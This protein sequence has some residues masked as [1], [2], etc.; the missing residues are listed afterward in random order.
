MVD[1]LARLLCMRSEVVD[2]K[3][4]EEAKTAR[5]RAKYFFATNFL[6]HPFLKSTKHSLTTVCFR[7]RMTNADGS[8][9]N[10]HSSSKER[11]RLKSQS[12]DH[13]Y[14]KF[15]PP[16]EYLD[17]IQQ[18]GMAGGASHTLPHGGA[19][20]SPALRHA[21]MGGIP[22]AADMTR[23]QLH[24]QALEGDVREIK[25]ILR[26]FINRMNEKDATGKI[27]KEWRI[28]AR[29][30]DR[31]FFFIYISTIITSLATIFPKN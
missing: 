5:A 1:G 28:V 10:K 29:V 31:F 23:S 8:S 9:H 15:H 13:K 14:S 21:Q 26:T 24:S 16:P 6:R 3:E 4:E 7:S 19:S 25:R 11:K 22:S 20:I 27:A 17:T 30:L 2:P 18:D 12:N